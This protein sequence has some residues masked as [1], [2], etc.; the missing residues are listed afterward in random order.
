MFLLSLRD[1][2]TASAR[3][4]TSRS[5]SVVCVP[6]DLPRTLETQTHGLGSRECGH[7]SHGLWPRVQLIHHVDAHDCPVV[8]FTMLRLHPTTITITTRELNDSERRSRYRKHLRHSCQV[9]KRLDGAS[10]PIRDAVPSGEPHTRQE[11]PARKTNQPPTLITR[12]ITRN[13]DEPRSPAPSLDEGSEL[14]ITYTT[15]EEHMPVFDSDT[16]A[17]LHAELRALTLRPRSTIG[18]ESTL[19]VEHISSHRR[20]HDTDDSRAEQDTGSQ[21]NVQLHL[22]PP[23]AHPSPGRYHADEERNSEQ[24]QGPMRPEV[25]ARD[26][27]ATT[28]LVAGE[29]DAITPRRHLPVYNDRLPTRE[30]PQT[31]R[32]LPEARH[33]SRF[34]GVYT[35]PAGGRRQRV[36]AQQTPSAAGRRVRARRNRSPTGLSIPGFQGLYGGNENADDD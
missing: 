8:R 15:P 18:T 14:E 12:D 31:P 20:L 22:R 4:N 35:A 23:T 25:A 21:D 32:E 3:L 33:Q 9:G 28:S 13:D 24:D 7:D 2:P 6:I 17:L 26:P 34:E 10:S 1:Y 36:E 30:Q 19:E 16:I 11:D 29:L 27:I 5:Y